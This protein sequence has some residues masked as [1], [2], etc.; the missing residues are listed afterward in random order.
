MIDKIK[1][2]RIKFTYSE[3]Y[4]PTPR[5]RKLRYRDAAGE[6]S[7]EVTLLT[8]PD[9]D[10]P[11]AFRFPE[12]RLTQAMGKDYWGEKKERVKK[13]IRLFNGKL[14]ERDHMGNHFCQG[15]GWYD[16]DEFARHFQNF[17]RRYSYELGK[18]PDTLEEYQ[19]AIRFHAESVILM[20]HGENE[21]GVW[22]ECGEPRY[23][24]NTFGLGHNHGGTGLFIE[25][26]YNSNIPNTHY[27][28]ALERDRAIEAAI[29][30]AVRR[31]DDQSVT[32]I[33]SCEEIEVL[34]PDAVQVRPM[35]DHG[36]GDLFQNLLNELTAGADSAFEA[37]LLVLAAAAKESGGNTNNV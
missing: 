18:C 16:L 28:N 31:G 26:H 3:G 12:W 29:D 11:I 15:Q 35:R 17:Q 21:I 22:I 36:E 8:E 1:I 14:Y 13:E 2:D 4:L 6:T 24:Y 32:G 33:R 25:Q 10:A 34:I 23:V 20:R 9:K 37:G 27:Y 30:A 5:C 7:A 19:E